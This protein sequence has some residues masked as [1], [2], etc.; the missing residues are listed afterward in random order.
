MALHRNAYKL[1]GR[2]APLAVQLE[3]YVPP[4]SKLAASVS[5]DSLLPPSIRAISSW[6]DFPL[7]SEEHTSELQSPYD[8]VCRLLLEKKKRIVSRRRNPYF[9]ISTTRPLTSS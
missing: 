4:F 5:A 1:A 6:R 2:A 8:L 9:E 3:A 7:R